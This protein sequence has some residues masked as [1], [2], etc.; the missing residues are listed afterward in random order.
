M[1]PGLARALEQPLPSGG[2]D[3]GV[4]LRQSDLP[5]GP[6]RSAERR[7]AIRARQQRVLDAMP[8]GEFRVKRRYRSV[9][10]FACRAGRGQIDA[11]ARHPEVETLYL[12]GRV[13]AVLSQ[14][15][16]L[17]G[18]N[19]AQSLGFTGAGVKVAVIDTGIDTDHP[20]LSGA[21]AAQQCFCEGRPSPNH[22]C[23][24]NNGDTDASAED[25]D[26]HGTS[27]AGIIASS[28]SV[29]PLGV[30]PGAG[31]VAIKV[32]DA[33]GSGSFADVDAALDWGLTERLVPG[34]PVAGTRVVNLSLSD[35]LEYNDPTASPCAG[36][37]TANLIDS[38]QAAGVAVFAA[39][40]NDGHDDGISFPA[41][42]SNAISVGGVYDANVGS[43]SWCANASCSAI[44]CTDSPTA[45]DVFVC[46][47]NS[48]ELLDLLAPDYLTTTSTV[49]GGTQNFGGTSAASPYAAAQ[50]ALLL[51]ANPAF[52]AADIRTQLT[53]HGPAVTNPDNGLSFPRSDV[54][55]AIAPF[56]PA[57][58]GNGSVEAGEDCDDGGTASGDCCSA[59]CSFESAGSACDD[60]DLCNGAETCDGAG[61]CVSGTPLACDDADACNG[62]ETCN[63]ASGCVAGTPLACD[64]AD[65]CN[66]AETCDPAS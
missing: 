10:G 23:C 34:G 18:A 19:S 28:G 14:G 44:L 42:V 43:V 9:A 13:Q 46:H 61:S 1:A 30:A 65:V 32:L 21:V 50:A 31:I 47:S 64:D 22:G 45:A 63:P 38:L 41:C 6:G 36:S 60:G 48:D 5:A 2:I 51:E 62:A 29:A 20:D 57:V 24:P 37:N 8:A 3:I 58:C 4:V 33:N 7:A 52:S 25:D 49:G 53:S 39:S 11:L 59:T 16:A 27:V 17:I 35:G 15:G 26:G 56:A 55:A 40:G 66:G 54:G 12:D